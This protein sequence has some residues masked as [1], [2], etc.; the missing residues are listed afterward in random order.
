MHLSRFCEGIRVLSHISVYQELTSMQLHSLYAV[1]M[2]TIIV[3]LGLALASSGCAVSPDYI[4]PSDFQGELESR[5]AQAKSHVVV[6][7]NRAD[8]ESI[9]LQW[10]QQ[11]QSVLAHNPRM[12]E[13]F[14]DLRSELPAVP[15]DADIIELARRV[16]ADHV[17]IA[18]VA[19]KPTMK[20]P[21]SFAYVA[22]QNFAIRS[23]ALV[24]SSAVHCTL[25]VTN[26]Q[27]VVN[28]LVSVA[29]GIGGHT[30]DTEALITNGN[31]IC[32]DA[33]RSDSSWL[34]SSTR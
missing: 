24:W 14:A 32:Q 31:R 23:R 27:P 26:P 9:I 4:V 6:W 34:E 29:L 2:R 28:Q 5:T 22:V 7:S 13:D 33:E 25:P 1:Q 21:D 15:E 18:E 3:V 8:I 20:R 30:A 17:L 11:S 12:Q 19:T 10:L 16:S